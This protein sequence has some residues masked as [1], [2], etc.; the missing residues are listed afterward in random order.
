MEMKI[1]KVREELQEIK[2][3]NTEGSAEHTDDVELKKLQ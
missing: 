2:N 3:C 1:K